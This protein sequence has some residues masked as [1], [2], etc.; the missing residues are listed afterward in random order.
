MKTQQSTMEKC[1]N[2]I[3]GLEPEHFENVSLSISKN[4][5][6][7]VKLDDFKSLFVSETI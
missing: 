2:F 1:E 5:F 3:N 4:N 7:I 6:Y